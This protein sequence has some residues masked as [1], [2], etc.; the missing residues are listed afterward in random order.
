[1]RARRWEAGDLPPGPVAKICGLT[2]LEDVLLARALGA[3][4]L[5]FVFAPSP[6]RLTPAEARRLID[7][8]VG[9]REPAGAVAV[10]RPVAPLA[11]GVFGKVTGAEIARVVE[12]VGL[13]A[14]QLHGV[15]GPESGEVREALAG[16]VCPLALRSCELAS[17]GTRTVLIIQ[18]VPVPS[19]G[20]GPEQ[21]RQAV[22]AA[23]AEADLILFDTQS[24][25]GFGGTGATFPWRLAREAAVG[26]PFLVA[27]GIR[28]DN[29]ETALR[30][31]GAWGVDVSSGVESSPGK[32]DPG[33]VGRLLARVGATPKPDPATRSMYERQEGSKT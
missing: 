15:S 9:S 21:L 32:K 5:G 16:W 10:A 24:S 20:I 8:V 17:P 4:A 13:D 29:V 27:G 30:T 1:M 3:W 22:L 14:V 6:R 19:E 12:Q 23:G 2:R 11:V 28:P 31:S 25:T 7:G 26:E 18:A 33:L